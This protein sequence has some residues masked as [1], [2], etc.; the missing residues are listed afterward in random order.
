MQLYSKCVK[1]CEIGFRWHDLGIKKERLKA[2][3]EEDVADFERKMCDILSVYRQKKALEKF[4]VFKGFLAHLPGF[5]PGTFRLGALKNAFQCGINK[6]IS[7][8]KT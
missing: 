4:N 8:P 3:E 2:A 5:E 7:S 1:M 6:T